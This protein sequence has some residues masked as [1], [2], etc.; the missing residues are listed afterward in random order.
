MRSHRR[1]FGII[2]VMVL[3]VEK[4]EAARYAKYPPVGARSL[5]GGQYGELWLSAATIRHA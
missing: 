2:V 5:G 1:R 3:E 4:V